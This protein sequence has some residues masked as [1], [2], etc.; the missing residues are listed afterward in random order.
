MEAVITRSSIQLPSGRFSYLECGNG[1]PLVFLHALGRDASDWAEVMEAMAGRWRCLALDQRG[2]G[3]S[4]HLGR[5]T[6]EAMEQDLRAFVDALELD[7]FGL[8]THSMGGTVSWLFAE[9]T[10]D[11]LRALVV[12][13]TPLPTERHV[14][15][16]IPEAPPDAIGYDWEA[17]RQLFRELNA[18]DPSWWEDLAKVTVPTLLIG[19]STDDRELEEMARL[20]PNSES[21]VIETGH[22]VHESEPESFIDAIRSFLER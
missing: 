1:D 5:Y 9:A 19:G 14:Y 17:R 15:P 18:P 8:I 12:E 3:E 7:R 16:D 21:T 6:F 4:D 11:R 13:D 20:L 22:W 10:P 2:H